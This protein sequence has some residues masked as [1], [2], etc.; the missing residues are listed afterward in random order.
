MS[1]SD[2]D[3]GVVRPKP[4]KTN[5]PRIE[6]LTAVR[7]VALEP[8]HR[9]R[10]DNASVWAEM[11]RDGYDAYAPGEV[12]WGHWDKVLFSND[13]LMEAENFA[14]L[15]H[16]RG[17]AYDMACGMDFAWWGLYDLWVARD[18]L[19]K[20][21]SGL[22][23]Y[24]MEPKGFLSVLREEPV[25]VF[26]C[27]NGVVVL[28]AQPFLHPS[29]HSGSSPSSP[30]QLS[31]RT[32]NLT[33]GECFSS[34]AFN[35]PYD[36]RLRAVSEG[37]EPRVYM[38][39]RVIGVYS[40]RFYGYY[41]WVLRHWAV[42]W[43]IERMEVGLVM[44]KGV[45][46]KADGVES[47]VEERMEEAEERKLEMQAEAALARRIDAMRAALF[48]LGSPKPPIVRNDEPVGVLPAE[49]DG[50]ECHQQ[51]IANK[52]RPFP[53]FLFLPSLSDSFLLLPSTMFSL[54]SPL[55]PGS[56]RSG[57][58]SLERLHPDSRGRTTRPANGTRSRPRSPPSM[59]LPY[60]THVAAP[61]KPL[62]KLD[63]TKKKEKEREKQE[64]KELERGESA[65]GKGKERAEA[66]F[67][68]PVLGM[69]PTRGVSVD[70]TAQV[71][72]RGETGVVK[73]ASFF[74]LRKKSSSIA[75]SPAPAL[76][77]VTSFPDRPSGSGSSLR[78][79]T[80]SRTISSSASGPVPKFHIASASAYHP[81]LAAAPTM[82][83]ETPPEID[84][85]QTHVH[86][87]GD[88]DDGG[89]GL[90][91][92]EDERQDV[93][94]ARGKAARLLGDDTGGWHPTYPAGANSSASS[95]GDISLSS[96]APPFSP[97]G[98]GTG[99]SSQT[100]VALV[101]DT[102]VFYTEEGGWYVDDAHDSGKLSVGGGF[103]TARE[104]RAIS[105]IEFRPPSALT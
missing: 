9:A 31:F 25:D 4:G 37:R 7:N 15:I 61:P 17:G 75:S 99:A 32:S 39:P 43:W 72:T 85:Q 53:L 78:T 5:P 88:F 91:F 26:T 34:E 52:R 54:A 73:R 16:T 18:R 87:G 46:Q 98:T 40:W 55:T 97:H 50:W 20:S 59:Y 64:R 76:T 48:I 12:A 41:R 21:V 62:I 63:K 93:S 90:L 77:I 74:T 28:D 102:G 14:E 6:Y 79:R 49:S 105:P 69:G 29:L 101:A 35:M 104:S 71:E 38:N 83:Y 3:L 56:S 82:R 36:L 100:T 24:F 47:E 66:V 27:W 1:L 65:R 13:V 89:G 45:A 58:S 84:M 22:Y 51:S 96:F 68:A 19:G 11:E 8:L 86:P 44:P 42:R 67:V 60:E 30:T 94:W 70:V 57:H 81:P 23:P 33:A 2:E 10:G 95:L 92:E 80:R 103:G